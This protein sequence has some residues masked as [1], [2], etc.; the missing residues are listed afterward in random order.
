MAPQGLT[1]RRVGSALTVSWAAVVSSN[2]ESA[3]REARRSDRMFEG[4]SAHVV[5]LEGNALATIE[6]IVKILSETA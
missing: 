5:E 2:E 1:A 4:I 3:G 6:A